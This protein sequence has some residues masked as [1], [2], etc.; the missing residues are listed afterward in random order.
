MKVN[1]EQSLKMLKTY[2]Q[3]QNNNMALLFTAPWGT[4][5]SYFLQNHQNEISENIICISLYGMTTVYEISK[6]VYS[7]IR[8]I[9]KTKKN[10]TMEYATKSIIAGVAS[11]CQ[12]E[13]VHSVFQEYQNERLTDADFS[14]W[15]VILEDVERTDIPINQ[16]L[17]YI[18]NLIETQRAKVIIVAHQEKIRESAVYQEMKEKLIGETVSF[19][20]NQLTA[21]QNICAQSHYNWIQPAWTDELHEKLAHKYKLINLRTFIKSLN[22]VQQ[23]RQHCQDNNIPLNPNEVQTLYMSITL[24][25]THYEHTSFPRWTSTQLWQYQID[26]FASQYPLFRFAYIYCVAQEFNP[27]LVNYTLQ[28]WRKIKAIEQREQNAYGI[29]VRL[30]NS[31]T[32]TEDYAQQCMQ[33]LLTELKQNNIK[34]EFY[35]EVIEYLLL[36][37]KP[38]HLDIEEYLQC[39]QQN[40]LGRF[41]TREWQTAF[42]PYLSFGADIDVEQYKSIKQQL[43]HFAKQQPCKYPQQIQTSEQLNACLN[44]DTMPLS[45]HNIEEICTQIGSLDVKTIAAFRHRLL[46]DHQQPTQS[47]NLSDVLW[48]YQVQN[49]LP[50]QI[51]GDFILQLQYKWLRQTITELLSYAPQKYPNIQEHQQNI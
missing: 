32:E 40:V 5:K 29:I 45:M 50:S 12:M 42:P 17:G 37:S 35:S 48:L 10:K 33:E 6:C 15:V 28:E 11:L 19:A 49:S 16:I 47:L 24:F 51:E 18:K 30:R 46:Q 38:F 25:L 20:P 41:H 23:L 14:N 27:S 26:K 4:G 44:D 8:N 39:M 31:L 1:E 34:L 13:S 43:T 9:H 2:A 21:M 7:T 36:F 3:S 22:M